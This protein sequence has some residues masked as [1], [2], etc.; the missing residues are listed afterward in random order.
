MKIMLTGGGTGGHIYPALSIAEALKETYKDVE[1]IYVG[2]KIGLEQDILKKTDLAATFIDVRPVY[3][4]LNFKMIKSLFFNSVGF[5]QAYR[6]IKRHKP[7]VV[8]GTG[9]YVAGAIVCVASL[10]GI[11]S[12]IHEQNAFP[13]FTNRALSRFADRIMIAFEDAKS[14]FKYPEKVVFTGLPISEKFTEVTSEA[15]RKVLG[16]SDELFIVLSVGGSNGAQHL[17]EILLQT[18]TEFRDT[19]NIKFIHVAGSRFFEPLQKRIKEGAYAVGE[20]VEIKSY[21]EDMPCYLNACDLVISRAGA[22]TIHEIIASETPSVIIPSPNVTD[23]HQ[24]FNAKIIDAQGL[25]VVMKE[26]ELTADLMAH[27]INDLFTDRSKLEIMKS[28]CKRVD[29]KKTMDYILTVVDQLLK[30]KS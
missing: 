18:Y 4:K 8:I 12:A 10:L 11:P 21:I 29:S 6:T 14:R 28:N 17:N 27:V 5:F 1:L 20:N 25:G 13:G 2:S 15:A 7:D 9:G 19:P 3:R 26:S 23:D 22:S 16:F 24:T 30:D